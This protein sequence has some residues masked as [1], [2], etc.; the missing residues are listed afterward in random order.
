MENL[1][2]KKQSNDLFEE[3][4]FEEYIE[5]ISKQGITDIGKQYFD[6]F[7]TLFKKYE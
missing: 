5:K 6:G 7:S 2:K 3:F 1:K 4:P